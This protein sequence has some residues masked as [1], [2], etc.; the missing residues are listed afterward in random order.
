MFRQSLPSDLIRGWP[1]FADKNMRSSR[2]LA[3]AARG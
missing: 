2:N 1:R 3:E